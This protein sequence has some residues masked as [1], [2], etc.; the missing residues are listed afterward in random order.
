MKCPKCGKEDCLAFCSYWQV[1][2][3]RKVLKNGKISKNCK[4]CFSDAEED[5]EEFH[6]LYCANCHAFWSDQDLNN[7]FY[8]DDENKIRFVQEDDE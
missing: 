6:S 5:P 1:P 3:E 8:L 4:K 2:Y 7:G